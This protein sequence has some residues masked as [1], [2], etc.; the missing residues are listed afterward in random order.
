MLGRLIEVLD[1]KK[2]GEALAERIFKPLGMVDTPFQVPA[3]KLARAAQP[4]PRP[5]GQPMTPR[6]KVDD[7]AKY[8]SGGG[9][10]TSTTDDYLR[11]TA[12]LAN[13]GA[14]QGK[15]MHRQ[16]DAGLHDGRPHRHPA[17]PSAGPGLRAGLRGPHRDWARRRC[18]VRS[19]NM[20]GRATP[21]RC[22]GSIRRNS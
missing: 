3:A 20:A 14:F 1:G 19:A 6:F 2:L 17:G 22:S 7:G 8:E 12:M 11:F 18:R 13:G 21:A 9:G 4:G 15:R 10:L 16:A 5:N